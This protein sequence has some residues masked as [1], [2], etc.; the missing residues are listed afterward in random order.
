MVNKIAHVVFVITLQPFCEGLFLLRIMLDII[1]EELYD[2]GHLVVNTI[3]ESHISL[4]LFLHPKSG[5]L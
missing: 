1:L 4:P 3:N 2:M 5:L